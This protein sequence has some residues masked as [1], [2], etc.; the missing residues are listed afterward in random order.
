VERIL[1]V[2]DE[3]DFLAFAHQAFE[4][5]GYRVA[6]TDSGARVFEMARQFQ[7]ALVVLDVNMPV[8]DGHQALAQLRAHQETLDIPVLFVTATLSDYFAASFDIRKK[9]GFIPKPI[10]ADELVAMAQ[11]TIKKFPRTPYL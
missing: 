11:T 10:A 7:P 6:T 3:P 9:A 5:Q 8:V 2:D 4:H 1:I